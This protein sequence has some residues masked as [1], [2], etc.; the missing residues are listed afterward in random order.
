[1]RKCNI[2]FFGE[3][4]SVHVKRNFV[5]VNCPSCGTAL[6]TVPV[7]TE[8]MCRRCYRWTTAQ[9]KEVV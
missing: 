2:S 7:N 5:H 3:G 8:I 9:R 1:M 6:H 4:V